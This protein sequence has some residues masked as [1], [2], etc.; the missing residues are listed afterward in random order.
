M[1]LM[2]EF[3]KKKKQD[4][5]KTLKEIR[6]WLEGGTHAVHK[7][8]LLGG[9]KKGGNKPCRIMTRRRLKKRAGEGTP[10]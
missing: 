2:I 9:R 6:A 10:T 1:S 7:N 5:K 4:G 3:S 8:N